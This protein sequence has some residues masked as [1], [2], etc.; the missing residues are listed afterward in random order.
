MP[1]PVIKGT[2]RW[3]ALSGKRQIASPFSAK[4][5]LRATLPPNVASKTSRV[6]AKDLRTL[7]RH[8]AVGRKTTLKIN[9][10]EKRIKV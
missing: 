2:A 8:N 1:P 7:W 4:D 6:R 5:Q 3:E 10:A 9:E